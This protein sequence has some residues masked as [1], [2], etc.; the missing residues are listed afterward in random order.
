MDKKTILSLLAKIKEAEK[1]GEGRLPQNSFYLDY[2][3]VVCC[4]REGGDSRYPYDC[5]GLMV[6]LHSTGFIDAIESTFNIFRSAHYGQESPVNFFGGIKNSDGSYTPVSITGSSR[7][8]DDSAVSRY[9][10]Y[11]LKCAYCFVEAGGI[12]F[13]MRLHVDS[14]KHIHFSLNAVNT[15]DENKDFYIASFMEAIL[16]YNECEYFWDRIRKYGKRFPDGSYILTS[17]NGAKLDSAVIT[18]KICEGNVTKIHSTCARNAFLGDR[19]LAIANAVSL[20]EGKFE[21]EAHNVSTTE[22]PIASDIF[23]ISA[24]PGESV[25]IEYDMLICHCDKEGEAEKYLGG[26]VDSAK[27]DSELEALEAQEQRDF[28]NIRIRFEEWNDN[29]VDAETFN[30][31][32][33]SVQKQVTICAHGKNYAGQYLGVRDVFQQIEGA[34]MWQSNISREKILIALG[35][36]LVTGRAPR[37]FSVPDDPNA[38]VPVSLEKY[39]DQ[40]VWIISTIYTYL[41]YTGDYSILDE[42]CGYLE[43]REDETFTNARRSKE[44]DSVLS[45]MKRIMAYLLS[46]VDD[47]Y[48]TGC[49]RVLF[50]DWNDA[51]DGLGKTEDEGK[52]FGS[53]V[54]VMATLQFHQNLREMTEILKTVGDPDG[55]IEKYDKARKRIEEGLERHAIVT[56]DKGERRIVHG[57]GDKISYKVGS[58]CDPDGAARY[59]LTSNSFWAIS[60][61]LTRDPSLKESIMGCMDAV[62]SKYGLKTF[63]VPFPPDAKGVGRIVSLTPGTY[64]NSCAYAHGSLFGTMALFE[65]GESRRAWEEILKT[66]VITHKNC[67]MTTF[68]MP[69][70]YCENAEYGMDGESMGDWHT[71]SGTVLIKETVR[72]GFGLFPTLDGL[73]IQ[74][75]A[76]FPA[77]RGEISLK[78]KGSDVT[79]TYENKGQGKR[80]VEIA[81][82]DGAVKAYDSLMG[83]DTYFIPADKMGKDVKITVVD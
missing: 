11:S 70:S 25:R 73:K 72:Y 22:L 54:T 2:D 60:K 39:I 51:V 68:A 26:E 61:F 71:G 38:D 76:Y 37:M 49:V 7:C 32:L 40:G 30:K 75:P 58:F 17:R 21:K 46:E 16:R 34:L 63:D 62:S 55:L 19:S 64:E 31:F 69:N 3:K 35:N 78:I 44:R 83:I 10:L 67:T 14:K 81:G 45:H 79:L 18:T 23:H 28:D 29:T 43:G 74:T 27:I 4:K 1:S 13:V 5:D 50:G 36:V 65:M 56:N 9:I 42:V 77:K 20:R 41:S 52:E 57:W 53:G 24:K 15:T 6:W 48:G 8:Y 12:V 82:A 59:S 66:A 33:R 47:E 80:T